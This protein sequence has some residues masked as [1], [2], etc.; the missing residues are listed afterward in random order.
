M[1]RQIQKQFTLDRKERKKNTH[2]YEE[3]QIHGHD[4]DDFTLRASSSSKRT[5]TARGT[6]VVGIVTSRSC[7]TG[8]RLELVEPLF[9]V[10]A[11][12]C[13]IERVI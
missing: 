2:T 4:L 5:S 11:C 12:I 3:T 7:L 6:I 1:R 9:D 10:L 13:G 8:G